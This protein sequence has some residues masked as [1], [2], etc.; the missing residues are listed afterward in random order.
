M[1][2]SIWQSIRIG[3]PAPLFLSSRIRENNHPSGSENQDSTTGRPLRALQAA[4]S[5][6]FW[7][8]ENRV[9]ASS[10]RPQYQADFAA[11]ILE[12]ASS[13]PAEPGDFS[14]LLRNVDAGPNSLRGIGPALSFQLFSERITSSSPWRTWTMACSASNSLLTPSG[15]RLS[16]VYSLSGYFTW[17][18]LIP[19]HTGLSAKTDSL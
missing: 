17:A 7:P 10:A 8:R 18:R 16:R 14:C 13:P 19:R 9:F 5:C 6:P 15:N 11:P 1:I 4:F 3:C 12:T 2:T